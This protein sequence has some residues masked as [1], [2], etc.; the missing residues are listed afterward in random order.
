MLQKFFIT[1][2]N[3]PT[4]G[5]WTETVKE[6]LEEM[7]IPVNL[8]FIKSISKE[9]FK[10]MVKIKS[11]EYASK[12]LKEQQ[13]KHSKMKNVLYTEIKIQSYLTNPGIKV[14]QMRNI[15]KLR[16]RMAPLG[17]NFRGGKESICCPLCSTH[18]D[19][20]EMFFKCPEVK[21]KINAECGMEKIYIEN[22]GVETANIVSRMLKA[23]EEM[24]E[25][26]KKETKKK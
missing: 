2:W 26:K 25:E 5:D 15:F 11:Q 21:K 16:T 8:E 19:N 17:E 7:E 13:G 6:N 10:K 4:K 9:R 14:E 23:R 1:Q 24:V 3:N 12:V 20:Q 18:L 22:V